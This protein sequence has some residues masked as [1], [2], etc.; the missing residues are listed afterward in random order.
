MSLSH[1]KRWLPLALFI[2]FAIVTVMVW[3][4]AIDHDRQ[5][6]LHHTETSAEQIRIR[7]QGMM[8]SR[9]ASLRLLA[10]RWVER[11]PPDFSRKRF[12]HFA[13]AITSYYPGFMG[14]N[15][16]DPTGIIQWVFPEQRNASVLGKNVR[17]HSDTDYRSAFEKAGENLCF[18]VTPS[19]KLFQGGVGF[20]TFWPLVHGGRVQG[21]LN[22]AFQ[23]GR[24]MDIC[25]ASEIHRDFL[26]RIHE[27]GRLIYTNLSQDDPPP[28]REG[29]HVVRPIFFPGKVW[30]LDLVPRGYRPTWAAWNIPVLGFGLALSVG[31]SLLLHSLLARMRLYRETRDN[32][33]YEVHER[34]RAEELLQENEKKLETL[35]SELEARNTELETFVY[36]VS[37]DLKTPI[38]TIEGFIG[39]FREDFKG[40]IEGDAE[41]YLGYMSEATQKMGLLINDLLDLSRIGR[42]AEEKNEFSFGTLLKEVLTP[43]QT[44]IQ[45]RG[46]EICMDDDFPSV[47]GEKRRIAQVM[48]NLLSNSI[49]YVGK[50]NP[51]PFIHLGV[52]KQA[53]KNVFYVRDNGIGI[54]ERYFDKVFQVFQRLPSAKKE[55][56]GTGIGLAIVKR[57]IELHG[58]NIWVESEPGKGCTFFFNIGE[59]ED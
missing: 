40:Q 44:M 56:A 7:V 4:G 47:Y 6:I 50:T 37:H 34:M 53:G 16:I 38:V 29:L 5:I 2:A 22:G 8:N 17:H 28:D 23:V 48:E 35:L 25:L 33:L 1:L 42:L 31:L 59:R 49:K 52:E 36:S 55:G 26:I 19:V 45:E 32:A 11:T 51:R 27:H 24:I 54:E 12:F 14:I 13:G 9:M 57:I 3:K 15:W 10:E 43:L 39:A 18:T 21:Y 58:G 20:D 46:I 30:R 41:R